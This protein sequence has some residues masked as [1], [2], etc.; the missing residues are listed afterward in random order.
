MNMTGSEETLLPVSSEETLLPVSS[1]LDII[2]ARQK[3]S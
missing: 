3:G 1:D 2:K